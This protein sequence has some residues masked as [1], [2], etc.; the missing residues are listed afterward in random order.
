MRRLSVDQ[1][2]DLY[3]TF[4]QTWSG[5]NE[6]IPDEVPAFELFWLYNLTNVRR[7]VLQSLSPSGGAAI[8]WLVTDGLPLSSAE[9][10]PV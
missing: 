6:S 4:V 1:E 10:T 9:V 8:P 7:A 2:S 5:L 3:P